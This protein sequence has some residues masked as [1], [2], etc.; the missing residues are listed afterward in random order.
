MIITN[1]NGNSGGGISCVFGSS[2]TLNN[3]IISN[4][5]AE[6]SGGGMMCSFSSSPA[7][8][9]V[10]FTGNSAAWRGGGIGV[11][12][13]GSNPTFTNVTLIDNQSSTAGWPNGGGGGTAFWGEANCSI[14]NSI[15]YGNNPDE[16]YLPTDEPAGSITI[17]YSDI[18]GG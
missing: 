11:S 8:T 14:T 3:V 4:N 10:I 18:Q 15:I 6:D 13:S 2:P 12:S 1:N 17:T 5:G 9:H 16:V 7:L